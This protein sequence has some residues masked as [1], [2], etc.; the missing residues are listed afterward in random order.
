M[1][2]INTDDLTKF[3]NGHAEWSDHEV[4]FEQIDVELD[5]TEREVEI[6]V[7]VDG[8]SEEI[9]LTHQID[10]EEPL[11]FTIN[12]AI[13]LGT[14]MQDDLTTE[15]LGGLLQSLGNEECLQ[16]VEA[17][18]TARMNDAESSLDRLRDAEQSAACSND[19]DGVLAAQEGI[20]AARLELQ[21]WGDVHRAATGEKIVEVEV[22]APTPTPDFIPE[23]ATV[24][25]LGCLT[26]GTKFW[27][28]RKSL[29]A[30]TYD[31]RV[32]ATTWGE[33]MT[34]DTEV[35]IEELAPAPETADTEKSLYSA[36]SVRDLVGMI[37]EDNERRPLLIGLLVEAGYAVGKNVS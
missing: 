9:S 31:E 10:G 27:V 3:I 12:L 30:Y 34:D 4:E 25:T 24:H 28:S 8:Y 22:E 33:N 13:V 5:G 37:L 23:G 2:N 26:R 1:S 17:L 36:S 20:D 15:A 6:Q 11:D 19:N 35:W 32:P 16:V 14:V 18:A 21:R 7:C 29:T